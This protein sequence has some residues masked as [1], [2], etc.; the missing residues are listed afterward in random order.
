M[1]AQQ[2]HR[3]IDGA[4]GRQESDQDFTWRTTALEKTGLDDVVVDD[5]L[6][7]NAYF[8]YFNFI[9]ESVHNNLISNLTG[10]KGRLIIL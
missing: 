4:L 9:E 6:S 1:V 10:A 2:L 3:R 5:L 8:K 7:G